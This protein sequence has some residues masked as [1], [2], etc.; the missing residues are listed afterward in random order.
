MNHQPNEAVSRIK[1]ELAQ[2]SNADFAIATAQELQ[3]RNFTFALYGYRAADSDRMEN[4]YFASLPSFLTGFPPPIQLV[5]MAKRH[6][7]HT[8]GETLEQ[9]V[10]IRELVPEPMSPGEGVEGEAELGT[11]GIPQG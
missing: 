3:R 10:D 8:A 7:E 1:E 4:M 6:Q 9:I 11:D 2:L 5:W